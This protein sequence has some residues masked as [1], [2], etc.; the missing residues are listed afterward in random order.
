MHGSRIPA[1]DTTAWRGPVGTA[2]WPYVTVPLT[3]S[4]LA[5]L[6][7]LTWLTRSSATYS[8]DENSALAAR[9]RDRFGAGSGSSSGISRPAAA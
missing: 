3:R 9:R 1:A 8:L 2:A 7:S 4:P 5:R 6:T